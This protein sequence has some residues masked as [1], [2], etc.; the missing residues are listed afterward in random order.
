MEIGYGEGIRDVDILREF[1]ISIGSSD[2]FHR[3]IYK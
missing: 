2:W 3:G 1:G